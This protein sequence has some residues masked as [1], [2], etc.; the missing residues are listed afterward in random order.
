VISIRRGCQGGP[1]PAS[2]RRRAWPLVAGSVR[3]R[4]RL[5]LGARGV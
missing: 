4:T 3:Y 5:A 2:P 1:A